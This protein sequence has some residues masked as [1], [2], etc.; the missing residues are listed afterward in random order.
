MAIDRRSACHEKILIGRI[1]EHPSNFPVAFVRNNLVLPEQRAVI[2]LPQSDPDASFNIKFVPSQASFELRQDIWRIGITHGNSEVPLELKGQ[3]ASLYVVGSRILEITT[4]ENPLLY[5]S[6]D[7][8]IA[9]LTDPETNY[10]FDRLAPGV[11]AKTRTL[12]PLKTSLTDR[13]TEI[14]QAVADGLNTRE[15]AEELFITED[16]F[17]THVK[18]ILMKTH[19]RS[20]LRAVILGIM[21]GD[22]QLSGIGPEE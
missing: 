2:Q 22:I 21:S 12:T 15:A 10:P 20:K 16:T 7:G 14:L 9:G 17:R 11:V 6:L 3:K 5:A 8:T 18:N 19:T 4:K 1:N 13:E